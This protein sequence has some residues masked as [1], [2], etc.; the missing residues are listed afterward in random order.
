MILSRFSISFTAIHRVL[1]LIFGLFWQNMMIK[2][3]SKVILSGNYTPP[4]PTIT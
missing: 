2:V 3:Q 4:H 1:R